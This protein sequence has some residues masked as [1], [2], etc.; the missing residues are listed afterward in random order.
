MEGNG[1]IARSVGGGERRERASG[2]CNRHLSSW[3]EEEGE[4][5]GCSRIFLIRLSV[6]K[7]KN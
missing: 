5:G 7:S 3:A 6:R 2:G 4:D 1:R